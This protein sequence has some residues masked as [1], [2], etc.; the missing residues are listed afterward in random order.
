MGE[1][2]DWDLLACVFMLVP[3]KCIEEDWAYVLWL[4]S[5]LVVWLE[6][7]VSR[8]GYRKFGF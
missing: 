5:H 8:R 7:Q 6:V 4:R 3:D 1:G 2:S